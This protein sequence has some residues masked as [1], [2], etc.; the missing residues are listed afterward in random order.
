VITVNFNVVARPGTSLA[1]RQPEP[2]GMKL[3]KTLHDQ[4]LGRIALI[5]DEDEDRDVLEHWLKIY[6]IRAAMYEII[7]STDPVIKAERVHRMLGAMGR[8]ND[9][10]VDVD[11]ATIAQTL[12]R[13]IPSLLFA[14]PYVVRPEWNGETRARSWG[15]LVEEIDKQQIK[16]AE[17]NWD[18]PEELPE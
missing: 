5:V 12:S 14:V 15:S 16:R 2:D 13:G 18:E 6:N 9:W 7:D 17:R 8:P 11:P 3:W 4:S 1:Q 10:Y